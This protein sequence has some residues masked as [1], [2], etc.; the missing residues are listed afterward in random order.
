MSNVAQGYPKQWGLGGCRVWCRATLTV[1]DAH[2]RTSSWT[3]TSSA[4]PRSRRPKR[5]STVYTS[6]PFSAHHFE[7]SIEYST[8]IPCRQTATWLAD[9]RLRGLS[10]VA[11]AGGGVCLRADT[12][13]GGKW[14]KEGGKW[15]KEGGSA[16]G[17]SD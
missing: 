8:Y 7:Y 4:K 15:A 1:G 12:E 17:R 16:S 9:S 2:W 3:L 13:D 14:A 6:I 10:S 11:V 5:P